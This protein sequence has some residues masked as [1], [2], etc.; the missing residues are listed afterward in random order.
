M[1]FVNLIYVPHIFGIVEYI[2]IW[3]YCKESNISSRWKATSN[4]MVIMAVY[5]GNLV[6]FL[7]ATKNEIPF[8]TLRQ[9]VGD[10]RYEIS[11][12]GH[13]NLELILQVRK[14]LKFP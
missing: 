4:F 9:L 6:A 3:F 10:T 5:S 13:S 11:L 7:T 2:L 1:K 12:V 8:H 14:L